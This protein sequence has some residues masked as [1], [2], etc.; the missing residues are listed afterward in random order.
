MAALDA[1]AQ[2]GKYLFIFFWKNDDQQSRTMYGVFK[3]AMG[4][5]TESADSIGVQITDAD[6]KPLVDKYGVN[7]APMPLVVALAPNGAVTKG[8]PVRFDES[9]L[10]EAFVSPCTAKVLKGVQDRKLIF[11]CIQNQTTRSNAAAMQGV[12]DFKADARYT[13]A[14][15]IVTLD[16]ADATEAELLEGFEIDPRTDEAVTVFLAPPGR[17]IGKVKGPTSK[18]RFIATLS[19]ASTGCGPGGC[20]PNGCGPKP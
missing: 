20:G 1:A 7:Q 16:P 4:K 13:A 17:A 8:F 12:A 15:E 3:S 2:N 14:T 10:R 6:E 11:L 5:W 19:A 9:Q 18:D